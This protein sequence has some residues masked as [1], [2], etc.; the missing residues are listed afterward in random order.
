MTFIRLIFVSLFTLSHFCCFVS[1]YC[2]GNKSVSIKTV[3]PNKKRASIEDIPS[4]EVH[5]EIP[6][7]GQAT[8]N[9]ARDVT[10]GGIHNPVLISS[11]STAH[12]ADQVLFPF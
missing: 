9:A 8:P 6:N 12:K 2:V 5:V 4:S 1:R 3:I 11:T 7:I 10:D